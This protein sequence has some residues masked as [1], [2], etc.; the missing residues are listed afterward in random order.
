M[1]MKVQGHLMQAHFT[2]I[3]Q[4][5]TK[6][7]RSDT[8]LTDLVFLHT[9]QYVDR[10][11]GGTE[12]CLLNLCAYCGAVV[13]VQVLEGAEPVGPAAGLWS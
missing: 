3:H 7:I 5:F 10:Y 4:V 8:F 9:W 1:H 6:K 13:S 2:E 12:N 11:T